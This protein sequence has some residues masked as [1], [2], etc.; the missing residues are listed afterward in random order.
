MIKI[1]AGNKEIALE[2]IITCSITDIEELKTKWKA[3]DN[4]H[5]ELIG[6]EEILYL[7]RLK[8]NM[9]NAP[10]IFGEY[11]KEI[12]IE[13]RND[14]LKKITSKNYCQHWADCQIKSLRNDIR[15]S[16]CILFDFIKSQNSM[17]SE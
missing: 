1:L 9:N 16:K 4:D 14:I 3:V 15:N 6:E 11:K 12:A 8:T 7:F 13:V 2:N 5:F 10:I 17:E